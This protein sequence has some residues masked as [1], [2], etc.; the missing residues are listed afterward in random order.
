MKSERYLNHKR[1]LI[2]DW[3]KELRSIKLSKQPNCQICFKGNNL[4]V[5]H[6]GY[7]YFYKAKKK[8]ALKNTI[9]LCGSCHQLVHN[10]QKEENKTYEETRQIIDDLIKER[11]KARKLFAERQE[12]FDNLIRN[13]I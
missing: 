5:H 11:T 3:W 8:Q 12:E 4:Q 7:K 10:I 13:I 2:S 6:I 9:V 1:F